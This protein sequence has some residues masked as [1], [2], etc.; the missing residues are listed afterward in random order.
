MKKLFAV[1]GGALF[2]GALVFGLAYIPGGRADAVTPKQGVSE[3]D[4]MVPQSSAQV[5][6]SFAPVVKETA[7]AVVNVYSE[8]KVQRVD[9]FFSFLAV[10]CRVNAPS[11]RSARG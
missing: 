10:V 2:G 3:Q 7:P 4:I 9:P 1:S 6:M 5:K 11:V 8:R